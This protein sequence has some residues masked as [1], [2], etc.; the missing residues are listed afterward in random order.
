MGDAYVG[1][2]AQ[3]KR[4][5]LSLIVDACLNHFCM[6]ISIVVLG[7]GVC[8]H[9]HLL[10]ESR[11][12]EVVF[13]HG[14]QGG[15]PGASLHAGQGLLALIGGGLGIAQGAG[16]LPVLG[17]VE[18]GNLLGLLN[19]LLVGLDLALQLVDEGLHALVV[20][21]VLVGGEGQ[22]LD[23]ALRLAQVLGGVAVA[24]GLGVQLGLQLAD[25][26]LHLDHGLLAALEGIDLGLVGAGLGILALGLQQLAVLLQAHG[27]VLLGA[28]LIGQAGGVNHG[29]GRLLLRELGLVGHL[30]EVSVEGVGLVL[31]L[32]LGGGNGLVLVGEVSQGL[33]GVAQLLLQ[34]ATAA[35][36][37]LQ[38]AA[39]PH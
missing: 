21:L 6:A 29:A 11:E 35:V 34:R 4:G 38:Q 37:L 16:H 17:Q 8:S 13:L 23:L 7:L 12:R 18:G 10:L 32:P 2:E 39:G 15:G 22:L 25:A 33:V 14:S 31:Q 28:E 30:V 36:G 27:N 5:I 26:G 1:D 3:S 24:P 19:L 20:L 9:H